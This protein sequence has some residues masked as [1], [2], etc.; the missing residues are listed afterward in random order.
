M[1]HEITGFKFTLPPMLVE[2]LFQ[3]VNFIVRTTYIANHE[4][5]YIVKLLRHHD[6]SMSMTILTLD[7]TL[8]QVG[9]LQTT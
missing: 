4:I 9:R 3:F 2:Q 1:L 7:V 8:W 6:H 5:G